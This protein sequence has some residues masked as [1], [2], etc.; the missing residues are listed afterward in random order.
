MSKEVLNRL[1]SV[2]YC[3]NAMCADGTDVLINSS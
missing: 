1:T 3:S 2:K